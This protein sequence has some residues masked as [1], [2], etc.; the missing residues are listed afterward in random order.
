MATVP[1]KLDTSM[2]TTST[3]M[4]IAMCGRTHVA[5][6]Q[7]LNCRSSARSFSPSL[8]SGQN[9]QL[10]RLATD[11]TRPCFAQLLVCDVAHITPRFG[12]SVCYLSF[13]LL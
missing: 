10:Q 6:I 9:M 1:G 4:H 13:T 2:F 11:S 7:P 5:E 8:R 3:C 12:F